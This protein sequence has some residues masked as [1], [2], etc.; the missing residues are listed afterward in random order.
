MVLLSVRLSGYFVRRI[1]NLESGSAVRTTA[2]EFHQD[3]WILSQLLYDAARSDAHCG[4]DLLPPSPAVSF[5]GFIDTDSDRVEKSNAGDDN[6]TVRPSD[7][8][9]EASHAKS[10]PQKFCFSGEVEPELN[11]RQKLFAAAPLDDHRS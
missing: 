4:V 2:G 10:A 9:T 6:Q 7:E 11:R 5:I 1:E 3:Y 8:P